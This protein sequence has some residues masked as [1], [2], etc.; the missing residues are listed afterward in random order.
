M[1]QTGN[2]TDT[3]SAITNN[4]IKS[5]IQSSLLRFLNFTV[6][7]GFEE[8]RKIVKTEVISNHEHCTAGFWWNKDFLWQKYVGIKIY[9]I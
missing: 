3:L 7:G 8:R 9:Q 4:Q 2:K 1:R 6:K 5:G